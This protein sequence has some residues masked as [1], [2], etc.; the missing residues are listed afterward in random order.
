M[1]STMCELL[2]EGLYETLIHYSFVEVYGTARYEPMD[3]PNPSSP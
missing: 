2:R 1:T 3:R